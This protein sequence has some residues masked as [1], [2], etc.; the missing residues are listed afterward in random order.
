[1]IEIVGTAAIAYIAI[2]AL[3]ALWIAT[4]GA[5]GE[6][7]SETFMVAWLITFAWLP[8]LIQNHRE[9]NRDTEPEPAHD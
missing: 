6:R 4:P 5:P 7:P 1:M 8:M 3:S 9:T 2:G